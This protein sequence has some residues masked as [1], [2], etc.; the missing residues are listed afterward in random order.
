MQKPASV[1]DYAVTSPNRRAQLPRRNATG[2]AGNSRRAVRKPS[3]ADREAQIAAV[4][5]AL[6][7]MFGKP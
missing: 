3:L 7:T 1:P 6:R 4:R 2:W 5:A